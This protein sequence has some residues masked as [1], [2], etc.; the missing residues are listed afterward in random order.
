MRRVRF[1]LYLQVLVWFFLNLGVVGGVLWA[2]LHSQVG[3]ERIVT[4]MADPQ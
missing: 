2:F 4:G 1:P 3:G